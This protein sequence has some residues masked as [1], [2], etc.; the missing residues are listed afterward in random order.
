[1]CRLADS[2]S[3]KLDKVCQVLND[4]D[5]DSPEY[6]VCLGV[7]GQVDGIDRSMV[8]FAN[9]G[10]HCGKFYQRMFFVAASGFFRLGDNR[11]TE[12]WVNRGILIGVD[13]LTSKGQ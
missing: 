13:E 10:M 3:R 1:M 6:P 12:S 2:I 7:L 9:N 5:E 8:S 4:F 11:R